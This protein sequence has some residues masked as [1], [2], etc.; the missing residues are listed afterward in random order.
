MDSL[1]EEEGRKSEETGGIGHQLK[2]CLLPK[3]RGIGGKRE[4]FDETF[5]VNNYSL[6]IMREK[7]REFHVRGYMN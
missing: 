6:F 4:G 7:E 2:L 5:I 3:M 1:F